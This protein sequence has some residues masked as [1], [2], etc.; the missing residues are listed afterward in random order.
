MIRDDGGAAP[1]S[2]RRF[3]PR[4]YFVTDPALGERLFDTV[5]AA[6]DGGATMVQLRDKH[7]GDAA[8]TD[9]ARRLMAILAPRR[10][11]LIVNDRPAVAA[12][13]GADGVH[14][15]Q[16]DGD[17]AAARRIVGNAAIVGLS[18]TA[19]DQLAAVDPGVVD[20]LGVGPVFATA[21]KP[22]AADPMGLEGLRATATLGLP[23]VAIGGIDAGN[24][25]AAIAA[26]AHGIAVVSAIAGA[27]DPRRAARTLRDAVDAARSPSPL[28]REAR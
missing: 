25:A 14:V 1:A 13:A 3:D 15:G 22:D 5:R 4:L 18:I 20:M 9:T 28:T 7:A 27:A 24:A 12:R 8:L 17:P 10:V 21:S 11:P 2:R 19:T 16:D 26:G 6:V 23:V